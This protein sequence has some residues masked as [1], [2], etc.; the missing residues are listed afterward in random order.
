MQSIIML[1][2]QSQ[3]PV[4]AIPGVIDVSPMGA[5]TYTVPIEVVPGTQGVQPNLSVVYNSFGGMGILGMKWSLSGLS[6]ITRCGQTPYHDCAMT[7]IQFSSEDRFAIDGNRLL[8]QSLGHYGA[9]GASY[10]TEIENFTRIVSQGG[11]FGSPNYFIAYTDDGGIIEYGNT[12]GNASNSKQTLTLANNTSVVLSWCVNKISDAHGNYMTFTYEQ[13]EGEIRIKEINY[14]YNTGI[15]PYAKVKFTYTTNTLNPNTF[16]VGGCC[17]QQ[18]Q[19]LKTISVQYDNTEVRRYELGYNLTVQNERTAHLKKIEL[20][21]ANE[22]LPLKATTIDWGVQNT[23]I[24]TSKTLQ[25]LHGNYMITGD[26]NGDGY[27]DVVVIDNSGYWDLYSNDGGIESFSYVTSGF[28]HRFYAYDIN[29]DGKD[30]LIIANN[31][32]SIKYFTF[33]NFDKFCSIGGTFE[34]FHQAYFGRFHNDGRPDMLVLSRNE[35]LTGSMKKYF[36]SLNNSSGSLEFYFTDTRSITEEDDK[37]YIYVVDLNGTGKD[38]IV[39]VLNNTIKIYEYQLDLLTLIHTDILPANF[40]HIYFGDFNGDG[41]K[42]I[43]LFT[44]NQ[45]WL[46]QLGLGNYK[47]TAVQKITKLSTT[48]QLNSQRPKY[49]VIIA[50]IN[51]DGKDEIIQINDSYASCYFL[52]NFKPNG[53]FDMN[54]GENIDLG[55]AYI[56]NGHKKFQCQLGDFYGEGRAGLIFKSD[57]YR[58]KI[59]SAN[60]KEEYEFPKQITDGLGKT[61]KLYYGPTYYNADSYIWFSSTKLC[62]R[63][64]KY[65]LPVLDSLKV[66][67]GIGNQLN[68]WKYDYDE[69]I[70]SASRGTLL[71]FK[72]FTCK[73]WDAP[74]VPKE[75]YF[76]GFSATNEKQ[77]LLP[78]KQISSIKE[79]NGDNTTIKE[80]FFSYDLGLLPN[81]RFLPFCK[82]ETNIDNL[83]D[84]KTV[85]KIT[86]NNQGRIISQNVKTYN[87]PSS[88]WLLSETKTFFYKGL[89]LSNPLHRKTVPE[90]IV[91]TQQYG[92]SSSIP[93]ITDMHNYKYTSEGDLEWED[94]SHLDGTIKTSYFNY[95]GTGSFANKTVTAGGESRNEEYVYDTQTERFVEQLINP[96]FRGFITTFTYDPKTGNKLSEI[97]PNGL[98]TSYHY[99]AFGNLI[100]V[101]N[102]DNTQTKISVTWHSASTPPNAKYYTTTTSSGKPTVT[103]YYDLLGREVCRYEDGYYYQTVYN[104]LGQIVKKTGPFKSFNNPADICYTYSYDMHGRKIKEKAPYTDLEYEYAKRKVIVTDKL[105]TVSTYTNYDALGRITEAKDEGG[106]ITYSYSVFKENNTNKPR[107]KTIITAAGATTTIISDLWG[108]RLS[109]TDPDAG[110]IESSYNN[111]SELVAQKD[112]RNNTTTYEYDKLGRVKQKQFFAQDGS[113]QTISYTYDLGNKGKGKLTQIKIDN[114]EAE[115]YSYDNYGRLAEHKKVIENEPFI[116]KYTYTTYGQLETLTYPDDFAVKYKYSTTGK[117]ENIKNCSDNSIIYSVI[118]RNVFNSITKC[119]Y[120]NDVATEYSYNTNGLLTR[121]NTG[122]KKFGDP[123]NPGGNEKGGG[124]IISPEYT[125]DSSILNYRYG[126]DTKGLMVSRSERVIN[127][128][129]TYKY[130]NIDRVIEI[131]TG[132]IGQAG[133]PQAFTYEN[134]GNI[135][136]FGTATYTYSTAKPHAVVKVSPV[137]TGSTSA[138]TYNFFNQPTEI[139]EGIQKL[140]LFYGANQQREMAV[141][142]VRNKTDYKCLYI[143]KYYERKTELLKV[144]K[145][146]HYIYGDNGVVALHIDNEKL[147]NGTMYY[148]HT[149][150]LGSYCAITNAGKQVEQ[151]NYF[152][153]WGNFIP[154]YAPTDPLQETPLNFTLINRG[155]T[156]HEHYTEFDIIN[157]NG[158][159]YDP[160]IGRFFSPDKYVAN[161]SFTQDFNRY[162]YARNC[163]LMYTDPSGEFIVSTIMA[164][165]NYII[166]VSN[167]SGGFNNWNWDDF[168]ASVML[169]VGCGIIG[170]GVGGA[171]AALIPVAGFIGGFASGVVGGF[172]SGIVSG[173]ATGT[174]ILKSAFIGAGIGGAI[175][176]LIGGIQAA[177]YK[178]NF[179]TGEV[180][181]R[182]T[183]PGL[184]NYEE[185]LQ[186]LSQYEKGDLFPQAEKHLNDKAMELFD[187]EAG[188][189]ISKI[190]TLPAVG[191]GLSKDWLFVDAYGIRFYGSCTGIPGKPPYRIHIAPE[192]LSNITDLYATLGHELV[193]AD[194]LNSQAWMATYLPKIW[195]RNSEAAARNFSYNAYMSAGRYSD[196]MNYFNRGI[197]YPSSYKTMF[198]SF[199]P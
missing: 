88:D 92:N 170:G 173:A 41:I 123:N 82:E 138:V 24:K 166:G 71:G 94:I 5:A 65:F 72:K 74:N 142:T 151:R 179:L 21:A 85:T 11:A 40:Q 155:F 6:A 100:K 34:S 15:Q 119:E 163:P 172:A 26:F 168:G 79:G 93:I 176:G 109:I 196:A 28:G 75:E 148:V 140:E 86:V 14:T 189:F 185:A 191:I 10:A 57:D 90:K 159:L 139:K 12:N 113:S 55:G 98:S 117:L 91:T 8:M 110:L 56:G 33:P 73:D 30:K 156:G 154:V 192:R 95:T 16:F 136:K 143:N 78:T 25:E 122:I 3:N 134:N 124:I 167:S 125:V 132:K 7:S 38:N 13:T 133:V 178:G 96:D 174:P 147:A 4:G 102:P 105:R 43:L 58:P 103:T 153:A 150:H 144:T 84:T 188:D 157:M 181:L 42:D 18:K 199:F 160:L 171:A 106:T 165:L 60:K 77:T 104:S 97:D 130:D 175:G 126:Y 161:S 20:F 158:R 107:H 69:L 184:S 67:N 116:H 19:L 46:L 146:Y 80:R 129:E 177:A 61:I 62:K 29:T 63:S 45:E 141:K 36:Y 48:Q 194:N 39:F 87:F 101:I 49:P 186:E 135:K 70:Y 169:G 131:K 137:A 23:T 44:S 59:L 76:F 32:G 52:N 121:I 112:A 9:I 54:L 1:Q 17:I 66:S 89:T 193:H 162:T 120:G 2:A 164:A 31:D 118:S 50:D 111:F 22:P 182:N 47:F 198:H 68:T 149:D 27:T 83:V 127:Q 128:L 81:D 51:G 195:S 152:D 99:D 197:C 145:H 114:V 180:T 64:R 53:S 35:M 183:A 37:N 190:T 108:N 187:L 115:T